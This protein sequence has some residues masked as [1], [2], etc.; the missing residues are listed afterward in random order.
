MDKYIQII[1]LFIVIGLGL[2]A[3]KVC[4][5]LWRQKKS[6]QQ[7]QAALKQQRNESRLEHQQ[8]IA[9]LIRCLLQK[10]VPVTEAA[11]RISGLAKMLDLDEDE[12]KQYQAFDDL[13]FAASHI[14]I[15]TDWKRLS[16]KERYK[17]TLE[18]ETIE[19]Q[20]KERIQDAVIAVD[21]M[22]N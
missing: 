22:L 2:Y 11:I 17:L 7:T 4:R 12:R 21:K 3:N 5:Q 10:Q 1:M 14:P 15:L 18:R 20:F 6:A 13:A 16:S 9:V 8:S 19:S